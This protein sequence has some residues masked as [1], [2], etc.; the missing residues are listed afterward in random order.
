MMSNILNP[1]AHNIYNSSDIRC[2][3]VIRIF[4]A[5]ACKEKWLLIVGIAGDS[6]AAVRINTTINVH[7]CKVDDIAY[8]LPIAKKDVCFLHHD[9]FVDCL[10]L[11]ECGMQVIVRQ[12]CTDSLALRGDMPSKKLE[13]VLSLIA[14]C[15]KIKPTQKEKYK[16]L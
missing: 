15:P 11:V 2:G 16:L 6:V 7:C 10:D 13:L 12:L 5:K 14:K 1:I 8:H 4:D 3:A 9:S